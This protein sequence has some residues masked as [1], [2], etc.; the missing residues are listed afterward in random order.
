MSDRRTSRRIP[1]AVRSRARDLRAQGWSI[2][3]I[4]RDLDIAR[5]SAWQ[6][7]KDIASAPGFDSAS[8]RAEAGRE[9]WRR[10]RA[11]R[12]AERRDDMAAAASGVGD[13]HENDL[14]VLGAVAYWAEGAKPS[15][16]TGTSG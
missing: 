12:D 3:A 10:E 15:R 11:K 14:L 8:R 4:A 7:T 16:G 2:P 6:L 5:S 9:Y 1:P 13:L